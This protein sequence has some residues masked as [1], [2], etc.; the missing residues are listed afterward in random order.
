MA[1]KECLEVRNLPHS[2]LTFMS[3]VMSNVIL[4][5]TT[6]QGNILWITFLWKISVIIYPNLWLTNKFWL[7]PFSSKKWKLENN[8]KRL[9][10]VLKICKLYEQSFF[11]PLETKWKNSSVDHEGWR[12]RVEHLRS[13]LKEIFQ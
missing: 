2:N 3:N 7:L 4:K 5:V 1:L 6:M 13:A 10:H 8:L 11:L 12:L 9:Q